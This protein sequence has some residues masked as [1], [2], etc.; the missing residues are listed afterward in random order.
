MSV[1]TSNNKFRTIEAFVASEGAM[2]QIGEELA[3]CMD[4]RCSELAALQRI[5]AIVEAATRSSEPRS[6][7]GQPG[8]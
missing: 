3:R 6:F 8:R 4:G 5:K 2:I 1:Q 7:A